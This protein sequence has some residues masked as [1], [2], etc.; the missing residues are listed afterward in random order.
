[1]ENTAGDGDWLLKCVLFSRHQKA[2]SDHK[3][4]D[5]GP[6]S[7]LRCAE[8]P[9]MDDAASIR[10]SAVSF[11]SSSASS[12]SRAVSVRVETKVL[13]DGTPTSR[14]GGGKAVKLSTLH[15]PDSL[16]LKPRQKTLLHRFKKPKDGNGNSTSPESSS[17]ATADK[18]W[19]AVARA[20]GRGAVR[21]NLEKQ[22]EPTQA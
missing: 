2:L 14:S 21:I 4:T 20:G 3:S 1:M 11:A 12:G 13:N 10:S 9:P 19:P 17:K 8:D 15:E 22:K 6:F 16:G 7:A 18:A 5:E